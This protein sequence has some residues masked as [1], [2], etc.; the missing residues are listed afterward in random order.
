M[1]ARGGTPAG[2]R[3]GRGPAPPPFR[4]PAGSVRRPPAR[5]DR[6]DRGRAGG[7]AVG[8]SPGLGEGLARVPVPSAPRSGASVA[9]PP[10]PGP[11]PPGPGRRRDFGRAGHEDGCDRPGRAGD[12]AGE[13]S[14][15]PRPAGGACAGS[16]GL[17]YVCSRRARVVRSRVRRRWNDGRAA[18]RTSGGRSGRH[19]VRTRAGPRRTRP[20]HPRSRSA[21][22]AGQPPP[23]TRPGQAGRAA[24]T[25]VP[26]APDPRGRG[27][28][29]GRGPGDGSG[30]RR[31]TRPRQDGCRGRCALPAASR[32]VAQAPGS[33]GTGCATRYRDRPGEAPA[34]PAA[35]PRARCGR[36]MRPDPTRPDPTGPGR[37]DRPDPT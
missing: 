9:V 23:D 22:T 30:G 15:G 28:G 27:R 29:R 2:T 4:P 33:R 12:T 34:G 32:R 25:G 11:G 13:R 18:V 24:C 5:P 31:N 6:Q 21:A 35:R 17:V 3:R 1:H 37:A 8:R 7:A 36:T 19:A 16:G 20:P 26:T 10:R 14:H